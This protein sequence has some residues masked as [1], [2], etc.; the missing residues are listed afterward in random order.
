MRTQPILD[1]CCG[2]RMMWF[3][4]ANPDVVFGDMVIAGRIMKWDERQ[5]KDETSAERKR[6]QREREKLSQERA[7]F[8]ALRAGSHAMSQ[9]VTTGHA[10]S[11]RGEEIREE[12]KNKREVKDTSLVGSAEALT[13]PA[14]EIPE[15]TENKSLFPDC[16]HQEIIALYHECLPELPRVRKW[17]GQREKNLKVRWRE[18]LQRLKEKGM[19]HIRRAS[20]DKQGLS[21]FQDYFRHD[22]SIQF[23]GH[24]GLNPLSPLPF[25]RLPLDLS[26]DA[27]PWG[28]AQVRLMSR[29]SGQKQNSLPGTFRSSCRA[30]AVLGGAFPLGE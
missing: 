7:E 12:F 18:T 29:R 8:E 10:M 27:S 25:P 28:L 30:S 13:D 5:S 21:R 3:D 19:P 16:P 15:L 20:A 4:K 22:A 26:P 11:L 14:G 2:S 17:D 1:P 9:D 24:I 23:P 6:L